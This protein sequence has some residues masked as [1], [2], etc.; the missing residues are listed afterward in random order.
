MKYLERDFK[1][2]MKKRLF[3]LTGV[4]LFVFSVSLYLFSF[5]AITVTFRNAHIEV[6]D[7]PGFL[8]PVIGFS[9]AMLL[10]FTLLAHELLVRRA[11]KR[12][13]GPFLKIEKVAESVGEGKLGAVNLFTSR[14][15]A[16][17]TVK[18]FKT[19]IEKMKDGLLQIEAKA[20]VLGD[21]INE[22]NRET[23][24]KSGVQT[25]RMKVKELQKGQ[26]DLKEAVSYF[27]K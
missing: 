27:K 19:M 11:V 18:Y 24:R 10:P 16:F 7:T 25:L 4:L 1:Q 13:A 2:W 6:I 23:S 14:E 20:E 12:L 8:L 26:M 3:L 17:S 22:L 15:E 5:S 9:L 21:R